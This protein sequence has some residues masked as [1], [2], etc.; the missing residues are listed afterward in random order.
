MTVTVH[1]SMVTIVHSGIEPRALFEGCVGRSNRRAPRRE[2]QC[3]R[4]PGLRQP[5]NDAYGRLISRS[6]AARCQS[7]EI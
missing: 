4:G 5:S 1:E 3:A 2:A 7:I 6:S